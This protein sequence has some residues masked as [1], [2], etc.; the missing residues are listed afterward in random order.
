MGFID[1]QTGEKK[2]Y[3]TGLDYDHL[4]PILTEAI[5]ELKAEK[6]AEIK[7]LKGE[8]AELKKQLEELKLEID[9]IKNSLR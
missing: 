1:N 9:K 8:N 4:T 2:L 6:D 5:K 7:E 3:V